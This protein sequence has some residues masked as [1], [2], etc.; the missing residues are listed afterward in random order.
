MTRPNH[1]NAPE[2]IDAEGRERILSAI[3]SGVTL[4]GAAKVAGLSARAFQRYRREHPDF[5]AEC[6]RA[7]AD[8]EVRMVEA[9]VRHAQ[10]DGR[11]ALEFLARRFPESWSASKDL[12]V[13]EHEPGSP[14]DR[15]RALI[16]STADP[17]DD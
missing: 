7:A 4:S 8:L 14:E 5:H 2:L 1:R 3:R 16:D 9:I 6:Q 11:L 13:V 10:E 17:F 12:R 15:M